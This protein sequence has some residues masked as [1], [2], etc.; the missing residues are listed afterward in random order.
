MKNRAEKIGKF[1]FKRN[2]GL[3]SGACRDARASHSL[4]VNELFFRADSV[5]KASG[6]VIFGLSVSSAV[7][8][9]TLSTA[10]KA[11]DLAGRVFPRP[12]CHGASGGI[13]EMNCFNSSGVTPA[14]MM[15]WSALI[16]SIER[17]KAVR[18]MVMAMETFFYPAQSGC[19]NFHKTFRLFPD[20]A[21]SG[22]TKNLV[23]ARECGF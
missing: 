20:S 22:R 1:R 5:P 17:N 7:R 18:M 2:F 3:D 19:R 4:S 16:G 13:A 9:A 14:V 6:S 10:V 15:F 21:E 8:R 23:P 12:V 11:D